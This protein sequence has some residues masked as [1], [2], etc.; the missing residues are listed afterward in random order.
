MD[1]ELAILPDSARYSLCSFLLFYELLGKLGYRTITLRNE[2]AERLI[3]K[4]KEYKNT[5]RKIGMTEFVDILL[6][7]WESSMSKGVRFFPLS[8]SHDHVTIMDFKIGKMVRVNIKK[9]GLQCAIHK[10]D[11]CGHAGFAYSLDKV[12]KLIS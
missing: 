9:N 10:T 12:Q 5:N 8:I 1:N 11:E 7:S 6:K 2:V 3:S 4:A